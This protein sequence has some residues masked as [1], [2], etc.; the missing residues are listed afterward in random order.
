MRSLKAVVS[1]LAV[2]VML[3]FSQAVAVPR[4]F[5]PTAKFEEPYSFNLQDLLIKFGQ[6]PYT[7]QLVSGSFPAGLSMDSSG[8]VT[9]TPTA[10]GTSGFTVKVTDSSSPAPTKDPVLLHPGQHRL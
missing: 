1:T 6:P 10:V 8:N 9:G 4:L 3:L 5:P 2:I 7:Y